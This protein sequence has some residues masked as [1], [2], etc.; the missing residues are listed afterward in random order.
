[1]IAMVDEMGG[2]DINIPPILPTQDSISAGG[3]Q[4]YND[5]FTGAS[6]IP[7]PQHINGTQAL[8]FAR[9]RHDFNLT[10]DLARSANQALIIVSALATLRAQNPGDAGALHLVSILARHV[11]MENIDISELWR[12]GR[13][14]LTIDPA[15]VTSC[16][17]PVGSG[18]GSNLVLTGAATPLFADFA[19]DGIAAC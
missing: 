11:R 2:I 9:D 5:S 1:M 14:A 19:A 12:L 8:A 3:D 18:S 17:T 7:G 10:G 15:A 16:M 6:F 4:T 13:Y